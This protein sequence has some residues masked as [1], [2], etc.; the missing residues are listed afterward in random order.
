MANNLTNVTFF[1][2]T[3]GCQPCT[4]AVDVNL[5]LAIG[6]TV[7]ASITAYP[8]TPPND[9]VLVIRVPTVTTQKPATGA[10][11]KLAKAK[12]GK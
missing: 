3:S 5:P 11:A 12:K 6:G 10:A 8:G 1:L 4:W 9:G 2:P 7:L